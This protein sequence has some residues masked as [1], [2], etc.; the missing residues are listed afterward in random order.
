MYN[1]EPQITDNYRPDVYTKVNDTP[2]IIEYQR[3][4]I[5]QK[6]IDE[7]IDAFIHSFVQRKHGCKTLWI[8][9]DTPYK[10]KKFD[11]FDIRLRSEVFK[12]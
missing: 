12:S 3:T 2:I 4:R 8:V 7:K 10:L 1:I 5:S 9:S 11:G 6:R